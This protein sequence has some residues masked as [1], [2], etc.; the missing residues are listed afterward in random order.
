MKR[1]A[2]V[3]VAIALLGGVV[4]AVLLGGNGKSVAGTSTIGPV[5]STVRSIDVPTTVAPLPP[6]AVSSTTVSGET[7]WYLAVGA[8]ASLGYQPMGQ[9]GGREHATKSSYTNDLVAIGATRGL[10]LQLHQIGCPGETYA[11]MLTAIDHCFKK[12]NGQLAQ[13]LSYLALHHNNRVLVTIDLGFNDVRKCLTLATVN[14]GCAEQGLSG[15]RNSIDSVLRQLE[16]AAGPHTHF[17]GLTVDDP[18]LA[19]YLNGA[20]GPSDAAAT[21]KIMD[22]LNSTLRAKYHQYNI[23]VAD[24]ATAFSSDVQVPVA[25]KSGGTMPTNVSIVCELTWMCNSPPW[26][27]DD[28]PN[29]AGFQVIAKVVASVMPTSW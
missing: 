5:T 9:P 29:N 4:A 27:P 19:H 7:V 16:A 25:V 12:S 11:S 22:S 18:F 15:V 1:F 8:S 20:A 17:V 6:T 2:I 3:L 26:G 23:P 14:E 13:A 10:A 28:H 21:L 24:V